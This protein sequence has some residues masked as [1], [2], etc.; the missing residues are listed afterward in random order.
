MTCPRVRDVRSFLRRAVAAFAVFGMTA[1]IFM[2]T[3]FVRRALLPLR[4]ATARA[5]QAVLSEIG[6]ETYLRESVLYHASGFATEISHGCMGLVPAG[7]FALAVIAFPA[8]RRAKVIG[9]GLGIPFVLAVNF[10][11][12]VHL[13]Y[14]GVRDLDAFHFAHL[15]AWQFVIVLSVAMAWT[16]WARTWARVAPRLSP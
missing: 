2:P 5:V 8:G 10:G 6:I 11:R 7:L 14:L 12:L 1:Y 3:P 13:F 4:E 16:V 15:Y 9:L